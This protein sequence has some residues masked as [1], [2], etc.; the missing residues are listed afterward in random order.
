[1]RE[2]IIADSLAA[3]P[4]AKLAWPTLSAYED[5]SAGIGF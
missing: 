3:A 1:M 2:Q 4:H 5:I